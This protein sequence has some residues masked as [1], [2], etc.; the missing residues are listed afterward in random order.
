[1]K[2][3]TVIVLIVLAVLAFSA[4]VF[5]YGFSW[6]D[7]TK[8]SFYED[9]ANPSVRIV[10]VVPGLRKEEVAEIVGDE[11][12]WDQSEKNQFINS[13]LAMAGST[14]ENGNAESDEGYFF[15]KSYL[16]LKSDQPQAVGQMM[17]SEFNNQIKKIS[18]S[19][20][21]RIVNQDTAV[22][23]A[24]IIQ[25]ESGGKSDM[26]LIS[27]II[28]NRLFA[29]M[30][31]QMDDTL[32]YVKGTSSDWWPSITPADK[33]IDSPYN[34]YLYASLPPSPID[35]PSIDALA[36]A[37][38]PQTTSCLFYLHDKS[39]NIHCSATYQGQL[40]NIDKYY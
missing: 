36:A 9:L 23:I 33:N 32:Q 15:P 4:F 28:W 30:K 1:M 31:L 2:W 25:R 26:R 3:K 18:K 17:F 40:N 13:P 7:L 29:G 10:K 22:K 14:F 35:S 39:G 5:Y 20:T 12:G 16:I 37:Y 21:T 38:N 34:T 27:G 19:K 24:S 6:Q 8:F 11:L